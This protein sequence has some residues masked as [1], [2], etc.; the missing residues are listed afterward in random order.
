MIRPFSCQSFITV[1]PTVINVHWLEMRD[2]SSAKPQR[3]QGGQQAQATT[4]TMATLPCVHRFRISKT[5]ISTSAV[6]RSWCWS[7]A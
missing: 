4:A 2:K 5:T 1:M 6:A 7:A 3:R